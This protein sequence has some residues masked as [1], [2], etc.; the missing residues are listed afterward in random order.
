MSIDNHI[1]LQIVKNGYKTVLEFSKTNDLSYYMVRKLINN[2][3]TS[4][5]IGLLLK[6]CDLFNCK[7]DDLFYIK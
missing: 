3:S 4:I 2:E 5:D 1:K 7:I 6:L